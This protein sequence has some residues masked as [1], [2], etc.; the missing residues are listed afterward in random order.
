MALGDPI[1]VTYDG[2]PKNL[3]RINDQNFTSFYYLDDG[4]ERFSLSVKHT[5]PSQKGGAGESHLVRLDVEHYDGIGDLL[6]TSSA[7]TVIKTFDGKQDTS[8]SLK[9]ADALIDLMDS[10]FIGRI[11]GRES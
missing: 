10:T 6:R 9:A 1:V 2:T 11:L 7:W 5:T 4:T 8:S 3:V